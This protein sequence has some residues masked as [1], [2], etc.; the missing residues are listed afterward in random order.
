MSLPLHTGRPADM[1][2]ESLGRLLT[3]EPRSMPVAARLKLSPQGEHV[4]YLDPAAS[5]EDRE[6]VLEETLAVLLFGPDAAATACRARHL[7]SVN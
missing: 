1:L 2:E 7:Y 5:E 3:I 4:L 6:R